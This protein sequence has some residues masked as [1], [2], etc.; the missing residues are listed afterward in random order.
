MHDFTSIDTTTWYVQGCKSQKPS[1]DTKL[2]LKPL[3]I[4]Q[5]WL[6]QSARHIPVQD[7]TINSSLLRRRLLKAVFASCAELSEFAHNAF[8]CVQR[9]GGISAIIKI[10]EAPA[11][12][13]PLRPQEDCL[14]VEPALLS[15][16][17]GVLPGAPSES[18]SLSSL[19]ENLSG[20]EL[21]VTSFSFMIGPCTPVHSELR[22][23]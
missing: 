23:K 10:M 4:R 11:P 14:K 13:G 20:L 5:A 18:A 15:R 21:P 17:P 9:A 2:T 8:Q 16:S 19:P 6:L 22:C 1:P 3:V 12:A 7:T